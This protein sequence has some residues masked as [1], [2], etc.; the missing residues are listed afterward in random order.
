[1]S[2]RWRQCAADV[3]TLFFDRVNS[4]T[5]KSL[6]QLAYESVLDFP[7]EGLCQDIWENVEGLGWRM[8]PEVKDKLLRIARMVCD[9]AKVDFDRTS[10]YITGSIT[11]NTF[12]PTADIDMHFRLLYTIREFAEMTQKRFRDAF[13]QV[14]QRFE[15]NGLQNDEEFAVA[16]HPVEVYYQPNEFQDFMSVGCYDLKREQ[17]LVGPEL[18]DQSYD[19]YSELYKD[20]KSKSE[21]LIEGIRTAVMKV[22]E[23]A[24]VFKKV[25]AD[26]QDKDMRQSAFSDFRHSLQDAVEIFDKAREMRKVYSSPKS[27]EQALK[28]RN[29]KKWKVADATF[30]LMDKFGYLAILK[31]YKEA[32]KKVDTGDGDLSA[33][34]AQDVLDAAKEYINNDEKLAEQDQQDLYERNAEQKRQLVAE[35][36]KAAFK[37]KVMLV[38]ERWDPEYDDKPVNQWGE[39]WKKLSS[40]NYIVAFIERIADDCRIDP[41]ESGPTIDRLG[42]NS[43]HIVKSSSNL[44]VTVFGGANGGSIAGESNFKIYLAI[45]KKFISKLLEDK[46]MFTDS[47]LIDW[48]NDCCDD[49]WTLRFALKPSKETLCSL[50][51]CGIVSPEDAL[52]GAIEDTAGIACDSVEKTSNNEIIIKGNFDDKIPLKELHFFFTC[53]N[54]WCEATKCCNKWCSIIKNV[55][56]SELPNGVG[57]CCKDNQNCTSLVDESIGKTVSI[58]TL[59]SF[60]AIPGLLP[61]KSLVAELKDVPVAQLTVNSPEVK[62]AVTKAAQK[63]YNGMNTANIVNAVARTIFAEAQSEGKD[64]Q[65]AVASVIWNRA[66]GKAENLVPVIS[67]KKQF[68][69]WNKYNGG[70]D[71]KTYKYKIPS[72]VF[73]FQKSRDAWNNCIQLASKLVAEE[74]K[75]TIGNRNMIGNKKLD[76]KNAW[77]SWGKYCDLQIG[78]HVFGYEACHDGFA[79]NKSKAKTMSSKQAVV[80]VKAGDTLSKIAKDNKTTVDNILK[81]N[82]NIKYPDKIS[83]GQKVKVS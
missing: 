22:Y 38:S 72:K 80:V 57:S 79:K 82:K 61:K 40:D 17:W 60:M 63:S 19:P 70:W 37:G 65:A 32:L 5:M 18:K 25:D 66:G 12:T 54:G 44:I 21:K 36:V 6:V 50:Y 75:S 23:N 29:S 55:L 51:E 10:V 78:N 62:A 24:V 59:V 53:D 33:E 81:L 4:N 74:F 9:E 8:L 77:N 35:A 71:D 3:C 20:I 14:K 68:S 41:T 28:Y 39:E 30:K 56:D 69:S 11:S 1:M 26:S 27:K 34:A 2:L 48:S 47:W 31:Q 58:A 76:N 7:S 15:S 49:V 45:V 42:I 46:R 13:E 52:L 67:K 83:V 73:I 64:G 16:G 43:V